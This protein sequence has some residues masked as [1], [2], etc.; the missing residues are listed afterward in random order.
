[1]NNN[2]QFEWAE[3]STLA[4]WPM[5]V[6]S[7]TTTWTRALHFSIE[8]FDMFSFFM[9]VARRQMHWT[10]IKLDFCYFFILF[11]FLIVV[12]FV[13]SD[14]DWFY[15]LNDADGENSE[16]H[17]LSMHISVVWELFPYDWMHRCGWERL[18][19]TGFFFIV[20]F[21]SLQ[22]CCWIAKKN[23]QNNRDSWVR[24]DYLACN[25]F[26]KKNSIEFP[27]TS[28]I[29]RNGKIRFETARRILIYSRWFGI[30]C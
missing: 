18:G 8:L 17:L 6:N 15:R 14:G 21:I 13:E 19:F 4:Q 1:M 3:C 12:V 20:L 28:S 25:Q 29:R 26:K 9:W 2:T 10:W 23:L 5:V 27:G 24:T 11:Y 30:W 22:A 7:N 16:G